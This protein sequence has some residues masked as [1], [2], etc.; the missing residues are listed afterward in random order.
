M[1]NGYPAV[2]LSRDGVA[3]D[4]KVHL[5]VI[6]AFRGPA[7]EGLECNHEDGEKGNSRLANL[8][9]RTRS[10]NERHKHATGLANFRG[11]NNPSAKLTQG[12]IDSFPALR[13]TMRV[14]DIAHRFGVTETT[15]YNY[16]RR[17]T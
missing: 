3:K 6:R 5:L 16:L 9:Y 7:P 13:R 17:A 10:Y 8:V 15:V 2:K 12:E 14:V 4:H 1:S 11:E